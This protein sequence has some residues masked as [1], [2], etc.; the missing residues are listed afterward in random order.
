MEYNTIVAKTILNATGGFLSSYTHTI[1]PYLG[2]QL[3]RGL[4][5]NYCYAKA[6]AKGLRKDFR[7][8][9]MY[10]YAKTNAP[11]LYKKECSQIRCKNDPLK[12]FMSS[13][14]DP[15]IPMEKTLHI[16]RRLLSAM[17]E[18]PPDHLVIQTHTPN[19]LW[20]IE[21]LKTLNKVCNL[22]VQISI[23]TDMENSDLKKFYSFSWRHP[24]S[25]RSRLDALRTIKANGIRSVATISPL[26]PLLDPKKFA[27]EVNSSCD[28]AIL[29]HYL[30]GDGSE[31]N[32]TSSTTYFDNPLPV[33][34][35]RNGYEKWNTLSNFEDITKVFKNI[36]GADKVGISKVGFN[37][38]IG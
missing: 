10:L 34:L 16:T 6:M 2:C 29:D 15:Y 19:V 5:G 12:I 17:V 27:E 14:T 21:I 26:L 4:C 1:N 28:F 35:N 22:S 8:W 11:E 24:Y 37:Q 9:G 18:M 23:E 32:R 31:G 30:I 25:I 13:V 7:E 36:L 33:I 3:G 20:D 38:V